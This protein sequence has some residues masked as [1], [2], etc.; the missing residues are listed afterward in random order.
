MW[1]VSESREPIK[2]KFAKKLIEAAQRMLELKKEGKDLSFKNK[3]R[4][5]YHHIIIIDDKN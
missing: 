4:E 1:G 2:G 3:E 5:P